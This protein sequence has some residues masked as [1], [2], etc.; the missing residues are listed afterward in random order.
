MAST[1]LVFISYSHR[2]RRWL[3]RLLV[4]LRPLERAGA[5]RAWADTALAAGS[6]WRGAVGAGV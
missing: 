5:I 2:D 6:D 3:D 4:H 1:P